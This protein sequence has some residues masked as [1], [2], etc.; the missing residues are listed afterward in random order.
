MSVP[1]LRFKGFSDDWT[2][3]SFKKLLIVN[4]GLQIPISD[5]YIN[6]KEGLHF[7]IPMNS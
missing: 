2:V 5:R 6:Y 3:D 1:Q 4:Q 7:Y